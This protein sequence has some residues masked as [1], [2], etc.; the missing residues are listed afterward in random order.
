MFTDL[1]DKLAKENALVNGYVFILPSNTIYSN[2]LDPA[3][4]NMSDK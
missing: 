3:Y 4:P 2:T 1:L